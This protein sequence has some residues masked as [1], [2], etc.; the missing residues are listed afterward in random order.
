[1]KKLLITLL[2]AGAVCTAQ[3]QYENTKIKVGQAAPELAMQD[4]SG[5]DV[6]LSQV[7]KGKVV[8]LDFWASW[9]RPCRMANPRV[10]ALYNRYKDKKFKNAKKGFTIVSVSLDQSKEPWLKAIQM[11]GLVWPDH[12]SDLGGWRSIVADTYGI[13]FIPQSMLIGA[14]GK[15]IGKYTD[16]DGAE[17]DLQKLLK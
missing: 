9:C 15:I 13:Q 10:V 14:D 4:T 3:A 1:M 2:L 6:K 11:D 7:I 17:A 5:K 16:P 12:M 8:L